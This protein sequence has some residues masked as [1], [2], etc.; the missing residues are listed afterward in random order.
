MRAQARH[1][2]RPRSPVRARVDD[3][4]RAALPAVHFGRQHGGRAAVRLAA[5]RRQVHEVEFLHG[6]ESKEACPAGARP[7]EVVVGQFIAVGPGL[8]RND[9]VRR[10]AVAAGQRRLRSTERPGFVNARQL[11]RQQPV[12]DE[13]AGLGPAVQ[14]AQDFLIDDPAAPRIDALDGEVEALDVGRVD[15]VVV[16]GGAQAFGGARLDG[17]QDQRGTR[18][19]QA[20]HGPARIV[21][22]THHVQAPAAVLE[23][24]THRRP[25]RGAR[26]AIAEA[27]SEL[28]E[29]ADQDRGVEGAAQC[30][31]DEGGR[32][33]RRCV[34]RLIDVRKLR[35]RDP[36]TAGCI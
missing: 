17:P 13:I 21:R 10:V 33:F 28:A 32:G 26:P 12:D 20:Q 22:H 14:A 34:D 31:A 7:H 3:Q 35:D 18:C 19:G 29:I 30:A 16:D 4:H 27:A 8:R 9:P 1:S 25:E 23:E 11:R 36:R 2:L 6:I 5:A 15:T 24:I